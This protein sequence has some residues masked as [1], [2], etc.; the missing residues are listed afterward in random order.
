MD[1]YFSRTALYDDRKGVCVRCREVRPLLYGKL[2]AG[3]GAVLPGVPYFSAAQ[4]AASPFERQCNLCIESLR[5]EM[6]RLTKA[7]LPDARRSSLWVAACDGALDALLAHFDE[8]P[9]SARPATAQAAAGRGGAPSKPLSYFDKSR[10]YTAL[11]W[12]LLSVAPVY[13]TPDGA[14]LRYEVVC[15]L[16]ENGADA[17]TRT[18]LGKDTPLAMAAAL[19]DRRLLEALIAHGAS[20]SRHDAYGGTALHSVHGIEA[21]AVLLASGAHVHA[22]DV[23][24]RTPVRTAQLHGETARLIALLRKHE[25]KHQKALTEEQRNTEAL[26]LERLGVIEARRKEALGE[27][28]KVVESRAEVLKRTHDEYD[29]W[30]KGKKAEGEKVQPAAPAGHHVNVLARRSTRGVGDLDDGRRDE[31]PSVLIPSASFARGPLPA[32]KKSERRRGAVGE[33]EMLQGMMPP[34]SE[35]GSVLAHRLQ[36]AKLAG[37][38]E[39]GRR[40][41]AEQLAWEATRSG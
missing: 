18:M 38:L 9:G 39:A 36:L 10:G 32:L 11:H 6:G 37:E 8:R 24:G 23:L 33:V 29:A 19:G 28:K 40:A 21:A 2:V 20:P 34:A 14:S 41:A 31:G 15:L 12:A 1:V 25:E 4:S 22:V 5:R 30:R 35:S 7:K 17:T 26:R 16:L 27:K 3:G 13:A